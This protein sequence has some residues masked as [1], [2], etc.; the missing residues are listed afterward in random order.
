MFQK[1]LVPLDGTDEAEAALEYAKEIGKRFN[2]Q[3]VIIH[4]APGYEAAVGATLAEPFGAAG[5][6]GAA[7]EAEKAAEASAA[8]YLQAVR[9]EYGAPEW[10]MMVVEGDSATAIADTAKSTG[11]DLVV[12]ATHA[13]RGFK[14]FF[15][16]SVADDVIRRVHVPVMVVHREEGEEE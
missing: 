2:S 3:M 6:V 4:V 16:G 1:I 8:G 9:E 7:I 15:L 13:R 10:T 5:S 11:A 14:R 12:M